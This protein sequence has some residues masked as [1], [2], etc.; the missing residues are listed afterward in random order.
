MIKHSSTKMAKL[1]LLVI[2]VIIILVNEVA[3]RGGGG[4]SG[5][6]GGRVSGRGHGGSR[7]R[8]GNIDTMGLVM[9]LVVAHLIVHVVEGELLPSLAIVTIIWFL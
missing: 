4:G 3:A 1:L 2:L 7:D 6:G 9:Y 5:R 8:G